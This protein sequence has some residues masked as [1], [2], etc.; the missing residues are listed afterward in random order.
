MSHQ[1]TNAG[2]LTPARQAETGRQSTGGAGGKREC[3]R[4]EMEKRKRG[5]T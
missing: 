5:G 2:R 3:L 1:R 4:G